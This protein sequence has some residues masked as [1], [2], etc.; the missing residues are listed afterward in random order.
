[1]WPADGEAGWDVGDAH[2]R[3]ANSSSYAMPKRSLP[4]LPSPHVLTHSCGG[5]L[6]MPPGDRAVIDP[7]LPRDMS[8]LAGGE[9]TQNAGQ[10]YLSSPPLP[11]LH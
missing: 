2:P 3:R 10:L 7:G 9:L 5:L 4:A 11:L 8:P 1:M 6:N